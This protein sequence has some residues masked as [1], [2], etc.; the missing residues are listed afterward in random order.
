MKIVRYFFVGG[1][2]AVVDIG[3]FIIFAKL[4]EF[5][6]LLV[7]FFTFIIATFVNYA[8][9]IKFVFVS[10]A[11]HHKKKEIFLVYVVSAMGLGL[12][13]LALFICHEIFWIE[14]TF[15]KLIATASVFFWNYFIR[16]YFIF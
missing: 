12:N 13:L 8:L 7:G 9:S 3:L 10:G 16:K 1:S 2:A 15:S 6:Y 14:L 11:R 5:N 4:L